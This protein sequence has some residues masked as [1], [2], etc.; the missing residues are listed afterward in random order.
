MQ[1][2]E[3]TIE[4]A[5]AALSASKRIIEELRSELE[6]IKRQIGEAMRNGE[7]DLLPELR[8]RIFEIE[9]TDLPFAEL[10]ACERAVDYWQAATC[11][12]Q[13]LAKENRANF[14][15]VFNERQQR[16]EDVRQEYH[17]LTLDQGG[18]VA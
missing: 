9:E 17:R 15:A 6:E 10:I 2:E 13:R 7:V 16:V 5:S 14:D 1:T 12:A 11:A 8:H 4:Q 18:E 3:I